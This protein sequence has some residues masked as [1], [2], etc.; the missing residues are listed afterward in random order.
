MP[1][2]GSVL[3]VVSVRPACVALSA[4][5]RVAG[6]DAELVLVHVVA[7]HVVHVTVVQV[8]LVPVVLHALVAAAGA[9]RVRM[10]LVALAGVHARRLHLGSEQRVVN[11]PQREAVVPGAQQPA[12]S[13]AR[14]EVVIGTEE[15]EVTKSG[16]SV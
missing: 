7:V 12:P 3:V 8:V 10:I 14:S 4:K 16:F 13:T 5:A 2:A 1:A 9:V 15:I 6:R 11:Q